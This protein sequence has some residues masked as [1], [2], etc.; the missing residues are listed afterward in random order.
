LFALHPLHVESVAWVSERKDVLSTF[1]WLLAMGS[2]VL[3][4][5]RP[6]KLR[7]LIPLSFFAFGL[8]AKPMLVTLPFVL[9]LMDYWPLGRLGGQM[10][11]CGITDGSMRS[12]TQHPASLMAQPVTGGQRAPLMHLVV[13]KLPFFALSAAACWM[14]I[15]AQQGKG[16]V[17]SLER[18]PI[19]VRTTNAVVSYVK[20]IEKTIWPENLAA[21]YPH[22]GIASGWWVLGAGLVL[23][24]VSI[25]AIRTIRQWPWFIVGWLWFLGT[26]LPVIGLV[27]VG[28]QAMADRYTYVPLI[29][30]FIIMAWGF[31]ELAAGW[32]RKEKLLTLAGTFL[33]F[34]LMVSSWFQVRH[35]KNSV[36]LF[37]HAIE[38]TTNNSLAHEKLGVA[39]TA[40]GNPEAA[41]R[42]FKE[43]L[44]IEPDNEGVHLNL[45][46][47][48][49][50]KGRIDECI[51]YYQK[52]LRDHPGYATLHHNL[53]VVLVREGKINSAIV[54]LRE[55]Y[56]IKPDYAQAHNSLGVALVYQGLTKEAMAHFRK[57]LRIKPNY[58][59]A[60]TNLNKT[61]RAQ[62][63]PRDLKIK[64][65]DRL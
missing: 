61:L 38:A 31:P 22:P 44:R 12:D 1:F 14:T 49:L 36:T 26:L 32:R 18:F 25:L 30:L 3:Y 45:A 8:M 47:A 58:S 2:Y 62:K 48:L 15:H 53:G 59:S 54:H 39:L 64:L 65:P 42:H 9:L 55:A 34:T 60:K 33:L 29:G 19:A 46:N 7:V 6:G 41:I 51:R 27:Q 20:Y 11:S 23:V 16:A 13:E 56:R 28:T 40:R 57:A 50:S 37:Q 35:W 21:Y 17:G 10:M 5:Q 24:I 63:N 4:V 43:A 52:V